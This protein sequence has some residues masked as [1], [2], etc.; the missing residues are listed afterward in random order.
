MTRPLL[1]VLGHVLRRLLRWHQPD[2]LPDAL[3]DAA[4]LCIYGVEA[5]RRRTEG[6]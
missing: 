1:F 6:Q 3:V 4:E 5:S 2:R